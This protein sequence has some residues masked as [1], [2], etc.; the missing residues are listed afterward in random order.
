MHRCSVAQVANLP[1]RRLLIGEASELR[2]AI[3][4]A[5]RDTAQRGDSATKVA[6]T[7]KSAVSRISQSAG[8]PNS[9]AL[10]TWK[11]ATQQVWKPALRP[12][13]ARPGNRRGLRR[14]LQIL[15]DY[16]SALR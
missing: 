5:T 16:K 7:S 3:E 10:P 14:F 15:I 8:H 13:P 2:T 9:L 4:L 1:Y 6:Q 12:R 11:S